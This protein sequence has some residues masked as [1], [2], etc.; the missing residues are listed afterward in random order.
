MAVNR[1]K[2]RD[3]R[4]WNSWRVNGAVPSAVLPGAGRFYRFLSS[5]YPGK[6]VR[7]MPS[8][9]VDWSYDME[10]TKVYELRVDDQIVGEYMTFGPRP[11]ES[12]FG[13]QFSGRIPGYVNELAVF[14]NSSRQEQK[15]IDLVC[16]SWSNYRY[17]SEPN[18]DGE[19]CSE[20]RIKTPWQRRDGSKITEFP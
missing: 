3:E 6:L 7:V 20:Y 13:R 4:F 8:K 18:P 5:R 1:S 17:E 11:G 12:D 9:T 14:V 2:K 10:F 15:P 19:F 16:L